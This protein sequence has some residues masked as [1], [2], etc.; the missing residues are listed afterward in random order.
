MTMEYSYGME[1]FPETDARE[2]RVLPPALESFDYWGGAAPDP[3]F[4]QVGLIAS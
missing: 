3:R 2:P 4:A 1:E